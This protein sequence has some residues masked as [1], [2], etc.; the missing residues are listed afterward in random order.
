M[1]TPI[2][3]EQLSDEF[4]QDIYGIAVSGE[5][6]EKRGELMSSFDLLCKADDVGGIGHAVRKLI[7]MLRAER[8]KAAM[9]SEPVAYAD[10]Q[11]FHNF[12]AG[13]A[14]KEWM[15]G[16]PAPDLVSLYAIPP[17]PLSFEEEQ[18]FA[19]DFMRSRGRPDLLVCYS[20]P[21]RELYEERIAHRVRCAGTLINE[22]T[23]GEPVSQPYKFPATR[24]QQVADLYGITS[25]TGSETSFTFDAFE[26]SSFAKSGWSVQDYV[27]LER[28][29]QAVTGN[30]PVIPDGWK[31]VPV[32]AFP[33]QWAAGQKALNSAGI[34]KV[35]AVYKAM[36]AAAPPQDGK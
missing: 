14:K 5:L 1:T 26:A 3:K 9:D 34:N 7:D 2:T 8:R 23:S 24:F 4:L 32:I 12:Q 17:A 16:N 21:C 22:D 35:D 13:T 10:P 25:P 11:A 28:Y 19:A 30:S 33:S 15:W 31:L 20:M 6:A 29:Q 18:R 27:E 36:V